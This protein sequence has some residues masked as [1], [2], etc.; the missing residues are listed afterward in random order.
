MNGAPRSILI[1]MTSSR[2]GFRRFYAEQGLD[3]Y[4]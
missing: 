1:I 3:F 2:N 4:R